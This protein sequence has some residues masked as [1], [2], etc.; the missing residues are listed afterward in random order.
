MN[1]SYYYEPAVD[2]DSEHFRGEE[3]ESGEGTTERLQPYSGDSDFVPNLVG[4]RAEGGRTGDL[5]GTDAEIHFPVLDIDSPYVRM[6]PSRTPGHFH[7]YLDRSISW[8]AFKSLLNVLANCGI[9]DPNWAAASIRQHCA[10]LRPSPNDNVVRK[11]R[12]RLDK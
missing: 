6:I 1:R 11:A 3:A 4:S 8:D 5:L 2:P 10:F 9:V 12:E 7:M